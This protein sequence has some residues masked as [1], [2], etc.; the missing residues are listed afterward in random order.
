MTGSARSCYLRRTMN[1]NELERIL[2]VSI[3]LRCVTIFARSE[4]EEDGRVDG[5]DGDSGG[6]RS[7]GDESAY[8]ERVH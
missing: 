7:G 1:N 2:N 8:G 4:T 3:N 6:D 5:D